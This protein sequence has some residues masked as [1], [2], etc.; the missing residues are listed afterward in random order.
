VHGRLELLRLNT[1]PAL[2]PERLE[3]VSALQRLSSKELRALGR[4]PEPMIRRR[5][6][7]GF[8]MV[9]W[10]EAC[11]AA[12][13]AI[14][15]ADP[16]HFAVCLTSRGILNEHYYAAQKAARAMGTNHVHNSARLCHAAS[17]SA[18]KGMLGHGVT[19]CA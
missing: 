5:G 19:T 16:E 2:D 9:S 8:R 15:A 14:R 6:E 10:E 11:D 1:A 17:T 4:L 18:V 3:D 7:R 12:A 13:S